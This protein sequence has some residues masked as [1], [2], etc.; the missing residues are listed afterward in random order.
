MSLLLTRD[1]VMRVLQMPDCIEVVDWRRFP[2]GGDAPP[3][4]FDSGSV[5]RHSD[6]RHHPPLVGAEDAEGENRSLME[7]KGDFYEA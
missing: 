5:Y 7:S 4:W 6:I 1:D 2:A 3:P